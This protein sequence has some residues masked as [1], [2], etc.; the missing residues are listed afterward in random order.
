MQ[1]LA[2]DELGMVFKSGVHLQEWAM[3]RLV[4]KRWKAMAD[5][6]TDRVNVSLTD[7]AWPDQPEEAGDI[8]ADQ[9]C[10]KA[11]F[12]RLCYAL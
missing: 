3:L 7:A 10:A 8:A 11:A 6:C 5:S 1:D 4:S 9:P 12:S 2:D